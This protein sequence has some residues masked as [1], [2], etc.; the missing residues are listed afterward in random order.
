M[1]TNNAATHKDFVSK[2]I[3]V[4]FSL[5]VDYFEVRYVGKHHMEHL[6]NCIKKHYPISVDCTVGLYC[7]FTLEWY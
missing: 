1:V 5:V 2:W 4:T 7:G 3:L 6:L